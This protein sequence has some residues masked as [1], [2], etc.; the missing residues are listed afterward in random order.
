MKFNTFGCGRREIDDPNQNVEPARA[1][2]GDAR[3]LGE[4]PLEAS[5]RTQKAEGQPHRL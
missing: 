1:V 3:G 5:N 2:A 4:L